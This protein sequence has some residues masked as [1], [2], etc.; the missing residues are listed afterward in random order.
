M[1]YSIDDKVPQTA[2][3]SWVAPSA[4]V[5]GDVILEDGVSVWWGAVLRADEERIRIGAGSNV[6]DNAVLHVDPGFPLTLGVD[7]TI[8]HLV[9]LHGCTIGDG[10]L[11]GIGA[12][13]L[14]GAQIGR[15]CLIG[16]H[17]LIAEG[18]VIPDRSLVLGMPGKI[19]RQLTDED[20]ERL[21]KSAAIYR[22][23]GQQYAQGLRPITVTPD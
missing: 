16:A 8:G 22:Q 7:V 12:T 3:T 20:I 19:V 18:K 5:V 11:I 10:T 13:I 15:N 6:Q 2:P 4:T 17:T 21:N 14:N 9:M 1:I 23:R